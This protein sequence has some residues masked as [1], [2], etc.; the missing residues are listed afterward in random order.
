M[1]IKK[2]QKAILE[3]QETAHSNSKKLDIPIVR[4]STNQQQETAHSLTENTTEN[5]TERNTCAENKKNLCSQPANKG[6]EFDFPNSCWRGISSND[7][8]LWKQAYPAI[9]IEQE[10]SR[11]AAWLLANPKNRKKNYRRFLTNWF[12]R[13]QD[14]AP[15]VVVNSFPATSTTPQRHTVRLSEILDRLGKP[16][17]HCR[18]AFPKECLAPARE[19]LGNGVRRVEVAEQLVRMIEEIGERQKGVEE[20]VYELLPSP[21]SLVC[22]YVRWLGGQEWVEHPTLQMFSIHHKL[23]QHFC[24]QQAKN[25]L[26]I[27]PVT[28]E[29]VRR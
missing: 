3:Y 17:T 14:R 27:H 1:N 28:G 22:Q 25:N 8:K 5:T 7:I 11:A 18:R 12:S 15:R 10:L 6:I 24:K 19:I 23:F 4:N 9:N 29:K 26:D 20:K 21:F 2:L 16:K 13:A